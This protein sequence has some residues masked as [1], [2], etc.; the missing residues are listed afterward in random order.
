MNRYSLFF[1]VLVAA[2]IGMHSTHAGDSAASPG[3]ANK[4]AAKRHPNPLTDEPVAFIQ[5]F[6]CKVEPCEAQ[7]GIQILFA[8]V[9]HPVETHLSAEFDQ[10]LE[11]LQDGLQD[12]GYLFDSSR[13]PWSSHAPRDRFDDDAKEKDAQ[14]KED[15]TPGILLFRKHDDRRPKTSYQDG[16]IVFLV[17]EQPTQGVAIPQV[18]TAVDVINA[19]PT[20]H[21]SGPVRILGWFRSRDVQGRHRA[22]PFT[23]CGA[24]PA[25]VTGRTRPRPS[26]R[27]GGH[28]LRG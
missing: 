3:G 8:T 9:P 1:A 20:I 16:I 24:A 21:Y 27:R 11:A 6:L 10:N 13:I 2:S 18:K 22:G 12:A 25:V 23:Q 7:P 26:L 5:R 17:S 14:D 28:R 4:Y 15:S 19:I